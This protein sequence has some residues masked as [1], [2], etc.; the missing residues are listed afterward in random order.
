MVMA[1]VLGQSLTRK[2]SLHLEHGQNPQAALL[3]KE[4][5]RESKTGLL[6]LQAVEKQLVQ[7]ARAVAAVVNT[8][9]LFCLSH[10]WVLQKQ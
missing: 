2:I 9:K 8:T 3:L 10:C 6:V 4:H 7:T 5:G 1:A